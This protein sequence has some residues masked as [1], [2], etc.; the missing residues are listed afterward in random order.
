MENQARTLTDAGSI[1]K[2]G[3]EPVARIADLIDVDMVRYRFP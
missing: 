3:I 2:P 1:P